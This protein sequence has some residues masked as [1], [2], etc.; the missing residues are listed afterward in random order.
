MAH[1]KSDSRDHISDE[2]SELTPAGTATKRRPFALF[3]Q[4]TVRYIDSVKRELINRTV[5]L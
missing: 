3:P 4:P 1:F 2:W 5:S